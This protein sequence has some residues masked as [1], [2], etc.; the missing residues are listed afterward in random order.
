MVLAESRSSLKLAFSLPK[1][2]VT[3]A[4]HALIKIRVRIPDCNGSR[5][6]QNPPQKSFSLLSRKTK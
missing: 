2:E 4:T 1:V 6:S 3:L 5:S